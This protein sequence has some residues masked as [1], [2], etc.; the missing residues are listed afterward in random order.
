MD[1]T[2]RKRVEEKMNHQFKIEKA[3]MSISRLFAS[4][5]DVDL[6]EVLEDSW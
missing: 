6:N 3:I 2:E 1:I 4:Q 5:L